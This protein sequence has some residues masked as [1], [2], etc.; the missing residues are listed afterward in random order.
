MDSVRTLE[1]GRLLLARTSWSDAVFVFRLIGN[2]AVRQHLGGAVPCHRR[3]AVMR[4]YLDVGPHE[5]IWTVRIRGGASPVGLIS[6]TKHKDGREYELSYQFHPKAWG[7]GY[8][9][10]AA[11]AA[12]RFVRE[13]RGLRTL[14]AETQVV[15]VASCRLLERLGMCEQQRLMRFGN[16]QAIYLINL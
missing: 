12:L 10:E 6:V 1:T 11:S 9:F 3:P 2:A 8:A 4:S 5:M 16:E 14:I 13:K 15:N 7:H